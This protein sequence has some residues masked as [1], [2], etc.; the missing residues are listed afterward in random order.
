M[1]TVTPEP[2]SK[3]VCFVISPIGEEGSDVRK[4]ADQTLKHLIRKAL[5]DHYDI[6]RGDEDSN[7]GSIT[8]QIVESILEADL[9]VADL[10]GFNPNVYYEVAVAHGYDKPTVHIQHRDE[11]PAFDLKDMRIIRYNLNDP[12]E[13][14]TAQKSLAELARFA[15]RTPDKVLTPLSDARRFIQLADS[16]DPIA[17]SNVEVIEQLRSLRTEVRRAIR[18]PSPAI[19]GRGAQNDIGSLQRILNSA[20]ARSSLLPQDFQSAITPYTSSEFDRWARS[21][22][23]EITGESDT[24]SL[25]EVLFDADVMEGAFPEPPDDA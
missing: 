8:S 2:T 21:A 12:D 16:Q 22:L 1:S 10:S 18:R 15:R 9:V 11:R 14:E 5:G 23:S 17:Q 24:D 13:L 25:N 3:P 6:K 7:P 20:L 4:A 19:A